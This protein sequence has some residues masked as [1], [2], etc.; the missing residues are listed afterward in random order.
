MYT[1]AT[2][3]ELKCLFA[4]VPKSDV[5]YCLEGICIDATETTTHVIATNGHAMAELNHDA[6]HDPEL[7]AAVA[8]W[9]ELTGHPSLIIKPWRLATGRDG[10]QNIKLSF[11]GERVFAHQGTAQTLLETIDAKYVDWRQ[12]SLAQKTEREPIKALGINPAYLAP[13]AVK[14]TFQGIR[15]SFPGGEN[16]AVRVECTGELSRITGVVMPIRI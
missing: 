5:R 13:F 3:T 9:C 8:T 4:S 14:N 7:A 2:T 16:S 10:R 12:V 15:L 6:D 1:I 11:E